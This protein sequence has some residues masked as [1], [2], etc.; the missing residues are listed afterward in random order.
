M[1]EYLIALRS[2]GSIPLEIAVSDTDT[3]KASTMISKTVDFVRTKRVSLDPDDYAD[4]L[5]EKCGHHGIDVIIPLMDFELPVLSKRRQDF[6]SRGIVVVV[7]DPAAIET[8]LNKRNACQFL[9]ENGFRIPRTYYPNEATKEVPLPAVLKP[10]YGSGSVGLKMIDDARVL[11][12]VVP[13]DHILQEAVNG[14]EYGMDVFND[15]QGTYVHSTLRRKLLMRCGE[16]DSAEVYSHNSY[17]D[18]AMKLSELLRHRGNLDVDF[19]VD[20]HGEPFFIDLNP[21]FGGGYPFSHL[22]GSDY[23]TL[24]IDHLQGRCSTVPVQP[25]HMIGAKGLSVFTKFLD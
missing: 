3:D 19:I 21:R 10:I 24:L 22:A 2:A 11:P 20:E 8:T 18:Q 23:L 5:L 1:V 17:E 16:T 7:A 15:L 25:K 6:L 14:I 4:D 13:K 12:A 9:E